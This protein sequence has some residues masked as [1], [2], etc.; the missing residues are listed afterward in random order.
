MKQDH[1]EMC[2]VKRVAAASIRQTNWSS[3]PTGSFLLGQ[4]LTVQKRREDSYG[5]EW[6]QT[7]FSPCILFLFFPQA[8]VDILL[9]F[10]L[11][12]YFTSFL[13][14]SLFPQCL[15]CS[16]V[17]ILIA[18]STLISSL[19][20]YLLSLSLICLFMS[21]SH[22]NIAGLQSCAAEGK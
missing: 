15:S 14:F 12:F 8:R 10:T 21:L 20:L 18:S 11:C 6:E 13:H 5:A 19:S 3:W 17:Y 9:S 7:E 22:F 16:S 2:G 4:P 1:C